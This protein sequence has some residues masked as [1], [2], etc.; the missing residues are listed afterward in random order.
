[1]SETSLVPRKT[2]KQRRAEATVVAIIEAAARILERDGLEGYN[3]NAVAESAG[4]SVG[5]L[6]QY[7]PNKDAITRALVDREA[8]SL[9]AELEKIALAS[10]HSEPIAGVIAAIVGHLM[11]RPNL[12]RLLDV[13]EQRLV[14]QQDVRKSE[15]RVASLLGGCLFRNEYAGLADVPTVL[16][17]VMSIIRG[18]VDGA[19]SRRERNYADPT[20]RVQRAVIGYLDRCV[21]G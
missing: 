16:F 13:E 17:D 20:I 1:M 5:S 7:F 19:G 18:M 11:F 9:I 4:I 8:S 10:D 6:Y 14:L 21:Q 15:G 3:T 2:P 12:A